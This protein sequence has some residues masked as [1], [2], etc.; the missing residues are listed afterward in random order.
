LANRAETYREAAKEHAALLTPLH[1]QGRYVHTH[2]L[3]GL[4]VECI[5]L[6]H[7]FISDPHF[8]PRHDLRSLA[9][10]SRF[11][12][13]VPARE[14]DDLRVAINHV[15]LRWSNDHRYRSVSALRSYLRMRGLDRHVRGDALEYSSGLVTRAATR[16]VT[17]GVKRWKT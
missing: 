10:D 17:E 7:K 11:F 16:I 3:A 12:D 4:A 13:Y 6:A 5:L 15:A 1:V 9:K 14:H 2:Y 8:D